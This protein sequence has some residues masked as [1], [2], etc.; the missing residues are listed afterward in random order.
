MIAAESTV[1]AAME[2]T[3]VV[4]ATVIAGGDNLTRHR[5]GRVGYL[6]GRRLG[7]SRWCRSDGE[8]S[9]PRSQHR[10]DVGQFYSHNRTFVMAGLSAI[11]KPASLCLTIPESLARKAM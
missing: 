11:D 4:A 3:T 2:A 8:R 9:S 5:R 7:R 10:C 1:I 6:C